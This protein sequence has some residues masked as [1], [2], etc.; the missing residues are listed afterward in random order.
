MHMSCMH[1]STKIAKPM[2]E[3]LQFSIIRTVSFCTNLG[4]TNGT[5]DGRAAFCLLVNNEF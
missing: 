4:E 1:L 2:I 3:G 5:C